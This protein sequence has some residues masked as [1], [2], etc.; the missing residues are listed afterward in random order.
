MSKS[1]AILVGLLLITEIVCHAQEAVP[2]SM[3]AKQASLGTRVAS[4]DGRGEVS[5]RL[6]EPRGEE[7]FRTALKIRARN[8]TFE[9]KVNFGLDSEVLWSPDSKAFAITGSS[10]GAN[11]LYWTTV[12]LVEANRLVEIPLT[13][14]I[15]QAFGHPVKCGWAESPNVGAVTWIRP[16]A[17]LL[18]AAEII[19]HSNCDSFGTFTAY[20][21]DVPSKR[22]IKTYNQLATKTLF[23]EDLG[24]E[25]ASAPDDCVR[26]PQSCYVSA[27]NRELGRK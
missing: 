14:K 27:N 13:E 9:G 4:P 7:P 22:I 25:L 10:D 11:G 21:I 19:H 23:K 12:F 18:V 3:F 2:I 17:R 15:W 16:S 8:K 1:Y 26:S 5:L 24:E 6:I 20:E